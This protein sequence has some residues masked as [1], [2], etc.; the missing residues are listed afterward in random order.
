MR[1]A[2]L[3][4]VHVL[5]PRPSAID[6]GTRFVSFGRALDPAERLR[7]L[8]TGLG[9]A[10]EADHVVISG[11]LT[12]LGTAAQLE[13]FAEALHDAR[14][15]PRRITLVPG[16]HDAYTGGDAWSR[17]LDGPLAAFREGSAERGVKI[18]ERDGVTFVPL[19]VS[20]HQNVL[21]AA[22]ELS[23]LDIEA[24]DRRLTD[25]AGRPVVVVLHHSPFVHSTFAWQWLHGLR[26]AERLTDVLTR[27]REVHV[28]HGHLHHDVDLALGGGRV[29]VFGA[30]AVVDAPKGESRV[31]F[32][33]VRSGI[34]ESVEA[35]SAELTLAA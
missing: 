14:I 13:T 22:G 28:L 18:V 7:K 16:N 34:L 17:A 35:P 9:R 4:D 32:Y 10:R 26:G 19:D 15:D 31:R 1:I 29:R 8:A 3:S 24:L 20:C 2:H 33:D 21:R 30:S 12:E 25:L 6:I 5:A 27:H 23:D 11:D